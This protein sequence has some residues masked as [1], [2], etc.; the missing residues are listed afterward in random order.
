M[1]LG[2]VFLEAFANLIELIAFADFVTDIV[3]LI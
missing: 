1:N 2:R 3:I